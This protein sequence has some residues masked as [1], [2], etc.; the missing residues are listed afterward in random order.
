MPLRAVHQSSTVGAASR[1]VPAG[2]PGGWSPTRFRA[3]ARG[4]PASP[5]GLGEVEASGVKSHISAGLCRFFG[6]PAG[7]PHQ[8]PV[9]FVCRSAGQADLVVMTVAV[10]TRPG[11]PVGA[12]LA[13]DLL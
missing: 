1:S 7:A 2:S 4:A 8:L 6:Q 13:E 3:E 9:I 5:S 12:S 11:K 10:G